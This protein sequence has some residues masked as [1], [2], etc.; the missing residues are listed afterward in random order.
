M[1]ALVLASPARA[2]NWQWVSPAPSVG[3]AAIVW[4]GRQYLAAGGGVVA[5]SPDGVNWTERYVAADET[6]DPRS[7]KSVATN[8]RISVAVGGGCLWSADAKHWSRCDGQARLPLEAVVWHRDRFVAVGSGQLALSADGRTWGVSEPFAS[9]SFF[10][11]ATHDHTVA[12][13]GATAQGTAAA[14]TSSDGVSWQPGIIEAELPLRSAVWAGN[15]FVAVGSGGLV[16]HS[17]D[18]VQWAASRR[19]EGLDLA[20]VVWTG[21]AL[22]ASGT[23]WQP[24]NITRI[25]RSTDGELWEVLDPT[26]SALWPSGGA[27]AWD[28][29]R[30]NLGGVSTSSDGKSWTDHRFNLRAAASAGDILVAAGD[31]GIVLTSVDGSTWIRGHVATA[32]DLTAVAWTGSEFVAAASER[33][34]VASRD[35][36]QWG[37]PRATQLDADIV[38]LT[39]TGARLVAVLGDGTLATSDDG[40][41][42]SR[43]PPAGGKVTWVATNGHEVVAVGEAGLVLRSSDGLSW[44][45]EDA[46]VS[47]K[48]TSVVWTGSRF[49]AVGEGPV[50]VSSADGRSWR[51]HEPPR[52]DAQNAFPPCEALTSLDRVVA[53]GTAVTAMGVRPCHGPFSYPQPLLFA[54]VDLEHWAP[55]SVATAQELWIDSTF[56]TTSAH[57][58]AL[59]GS[60]ILRTARI[61]Q[62]VI[63]PTAANLPGAAGTYWHTDLH[64]SSRG[65]TPARY[66]VE[67][68]PRTGNPPP[69]LRGTLQPGA[70]HSHADILSKDFRV[71]GAGAL[72][73]TVL[74]G[75]LD[76]TGRT[77]TRS[78]TG[79]FGQGLPPIPEHAAA[80]AGVPVTLV[81][82]SRSSERTTGYRTNLGLINVGDTE[83]EI[84]IELWSAQGARIGEIWRQVAP[85]RSDQITDVLQYATPSAIE[86]ARAVLSTPT[87]HGAFLAFASVIDNRT[88]DASLVV[89][90]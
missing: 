25:A 68:L 44:T 16:A 13:V 7:F 18:G 84:L 6:T 42:F 14:W 54:S 82:L 21:S 11:L 26:A 5:T 83:V 2:Q 86:H 75:D 27:L 69:P 90:R 41:A 71:T 56:L 28:G 17:L 12:A 33:T 63:L 59:R 8:G 73:V 53:I 45:R 9:V 40:I 10:G 65:A 88:G 70:S 38:Q 55:W 62:R 35:G 49:V 43:R 60:A 80:R 24:G 64:L 51:A 78:G 89:G 72:R 31:G 29:Q 79:S 50:V 19:V 3:Y 23:A 39:W 77:Y 4:D 74:T 48:L 15:R 58:L 32:A 1:L 36:R 87:P 66:L 67:L 30:L 85:G 46:N 47:G 81:G 20:Q 57:L 34:T 22:V 37:H 76:V 52:V 61:P